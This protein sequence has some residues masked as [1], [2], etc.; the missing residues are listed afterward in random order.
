MDL[1][2]GSGWPFGGPHIPQELA[3]PRLRVAKGDPNLREGEKVVAVFDARKLLAAG[4]PRSAN[5]TYFI[6][7]FTRQAVKRPAVGAEG[8]SAQSL[9][10]CRAASALQGGRRADAQGARE[11]RRRTQFQR[12]PGSVQLR[13]DQ[14]FLA[15]FQKRRGYDLTPHLP[16][17][18]NDLPESRAIRHDWGRR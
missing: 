9:R 15:E 10:H 17:L 8:S 11:E 2:L 6:S 3:S 12:Q 1:T 16:A 14:R 5:A 4:A 18:V 7:S 13:L